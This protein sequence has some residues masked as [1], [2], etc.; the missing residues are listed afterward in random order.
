MYVKLKVLTHT[1]CGAFCRPAGCRKQNFL[2]DRGRFCQ[3]MPH[4]RGLAGQKAAAD[5]QF[6]VALFEFCAIIA[7]WHLFLTGAQQGKLLQMYI[8]LGF[9]KRTFL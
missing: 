7:L 5:R 9:E 8:D 3:A 4:G 2:A 6:P 1:F